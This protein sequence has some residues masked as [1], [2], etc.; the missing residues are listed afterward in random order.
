MTKRIVYSNRNFKLK[1][2]DFTNT[3]LLLDPELEVFSKTT[4]SF[5]PLPSKRCVH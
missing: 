2:Q 1:N 4:G 5:P 3:F